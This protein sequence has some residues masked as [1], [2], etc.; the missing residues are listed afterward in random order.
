MMNLEWHLNPGLGCS[1][2]GRIL[3]EGT[4]LMAEGWRGE[5]VRVQEPFKRRNPAGFISQLYE[6]VKD[7]E[8]SRMPPGLGS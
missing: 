2:V 5:C 8:M 1:K 7:R 4:T 6:R 3:E